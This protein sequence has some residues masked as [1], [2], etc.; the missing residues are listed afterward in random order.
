M[1]REEQIRELLNERAARVGPQPT[2]LA[3]VEEVNPAEATCVLYDE[4]TDLLYYDVR[5]R[6]VID[7]NEGVTLFPKKDSWCLAARI[8]GT[9]EWMVIACTEIDKWRLKIGD[10]LIEQDTTGL[11]I[12]K[13]NDT[14]LQALE[15]IIQ[16]VMKIAV[17]QGTNP[18]YPKLQQALTKIKNILR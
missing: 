12:K 4:E 3:T 6:P 18:D 1:G 11:L 2:M 7:G 16:A 15:L 9:E 13:Q 8:E 14:L 10:T 17:I 5:L